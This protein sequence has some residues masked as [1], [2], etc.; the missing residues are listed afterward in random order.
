VS[1]FP[2]RLPFL[3]EL[4]LSRYLSK[5]CDQLVCL[6]SREHS[7]AIAWGDDDDGADTEDDDDDSNGATTDSE[8]AE[9]S[10]FYHFEVA[11]TKDQEENVVVREGFTVRRQDG[12]VHSFALTFSCSSQDVVAPHC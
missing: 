2:H 4:D 5:L 3:I 1:Q 10:R 11:K 12:T 9:T 6:L 8:K 7:D